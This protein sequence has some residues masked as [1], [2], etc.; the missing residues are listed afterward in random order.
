MR[1]IV[2]SVGLVALGASVVHAEDAAPYFSADSGKIWHIS[3]SL[4]GFYDD[5][6]NTVPNNAG[7]VSSFG[8]AITPSIGVNWQRDQNTLMLNYQYSLLYYDRQAAGFSRWEQDHLFSG[9]FDH[10]F[11]ERYSLKVTDSFAIGQEPGQLAGGPFYGTITRQPGFN[12]QNTGGLILNGQLTPLFGFEAG[13]ENGLFLFHLPIEVATMNRMEH[14]FHLDGRWQALP[15]TTAVLGYQFNTVDYTGDKPIA[16][17]PT[18]QIL[19]SDSRN[20]R[21]HYG[22]VGLDHNFSPNLQGSVRAGGRFTDYYNDPSHEQDVSPY[23]RIGLT[24]HYAEESYVTAGFAY[25]RNATDALGVG[26]ATNGL[27]VAQQSAS[28]FATV[29]HRIVPNLYGTVTAQF[30]DSSF[31]GGAI[32]G[33]SERYFLIGLNLRYQFCNYLSAEL[34][35]DYDK[36]DSDIGRSYDRN[37]VYVGITGTY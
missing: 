15:E 10:Q 16:L 8:Y 9:E 26:T 23:A 31:V 32:D 36:V 2:A 29:Y 4:R 14:T 5:N 3:A 13:Y 33:Q 34:G 20:S 22:Y 24:Y 30:Q 1:K 12:Y 18:G 6:I 25:D 7:R 35:Y 17:G 21:S 19:M 37:K 27:T 28:I 11:S